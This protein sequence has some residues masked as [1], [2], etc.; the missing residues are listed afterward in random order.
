MGFG[1]PGSAQ[2]GYNV[3]AAQAKGTY[4]VGFGFDGSNFNQK[5]N[6]MDLENRKNDMEYG[7]NRKDSRSQNDSDFQPD[8]GS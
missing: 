6:E 7:E 5:S 3:A 4:N 2:A 8:L 1:D